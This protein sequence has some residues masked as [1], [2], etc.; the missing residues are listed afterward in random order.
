MTTNNILPSE[1]FLR[2]AQIIGQPEV[3]PEQAKSNAATPKKT[4][5]HRYT[6]PRPGIPAIIPVSKTQWYAG[7]KAEVFPRPLHLGNTAV[8][9]VEDIRDLQARLAAEGKIVIPHKLAA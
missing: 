4:T 6:R 1:G 5:T 8:W 3:T 7:I 2:L 9:K